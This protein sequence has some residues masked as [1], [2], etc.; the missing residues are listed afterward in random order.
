MAVVGWEWDVFVAASAH[1]LFARVQCLLAVVVKTPGGHVAECFSV[2]IFCPRC[3]ASVPG[4]KGNVQN[5]R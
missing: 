4:G 5:Q 1:A 3:E 2:G